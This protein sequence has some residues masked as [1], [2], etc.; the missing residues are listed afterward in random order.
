M[1][2]NNVNSIDY[3][4]LP[5]IQYEDITITQRD[6][7]N[8][9]ENK[10]FELGLDDI[11]KIK[12]SQ[13]SRL[14]SEVGHLFFYTNN[15]WL[16]L[17]HSYDYDNNRLMPVS[18][19]KYNYAIVNTLADVFI[20]ICEIYSKSISIYNFSKF[21]GIDNE[22]IVNSWSNDN[23]IYKYIEKDNSSFNNNKYNTYTHYNDL[24]M[25]ERVPDR[26]RLGSRRADIY[27]KLKVGREN[28]LSNKLEDSSNIVGTIAVVNHEYGWNAD[29][30]GNN[31]ANI[32]VISL[33]DL[34]KLN[35]TTNKNGSMNGENP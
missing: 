19:Y 9:F 24:G 25:G 10:R 3:K 29:N 31:R 22:L 33:S 34:P 2:L 23:N 6:I 11:D 5:I 28:Y 17:D 13:F 8:A 4:D 12:A 21:T 15:N 26:Y 18:D 16:L 27:K 30:S 20:E 32:N 1:D 7:E 35:L 14:C